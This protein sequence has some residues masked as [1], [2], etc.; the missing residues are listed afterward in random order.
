MCRKRSYTDEQKQYI[1]NHCGDFTALQLSGETRVRVE[2]VRNIVA[3]AKRKLKRA[4]TTGR[5]AIVLEP[6]I[7]RPAAVYQTVTKPYGYL[8][9]LK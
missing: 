4:E 6:G 2:T 3:A 8:Y 7:D 9:P 1:L 5:P